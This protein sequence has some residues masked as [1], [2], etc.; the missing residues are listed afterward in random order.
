MTG[1]TMKIVG[2]IL[3]V[4]SS[5]IGIAIDTLKE[6]KL[7][8]KIDKRSAEAAAEMVNKILKERGL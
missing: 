3:S 2:L 8:D 1:K 6:K 7:N 4:A 5:G